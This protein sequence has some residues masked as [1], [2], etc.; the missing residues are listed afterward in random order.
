MTEQDER[1][2]RC[3]IWIDARPE[4]VFEFFVEPEKMVR[5]KGV[6][7]ELD[8]RPGGT[9]YVDVT[10]ADVARGEYV[11]LDPPRRVVFTW[12]WEAAGHPVPVG[13]STVEVTLTP[14]H[15][16]TLVQLTHRDLPADTGAPHLEGWGHY[17]ARLAVAAAGRDPG[18]DPWVAAARQAAG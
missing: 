15:N 17:L 4:T 14:Q 13:S 5:W 1:A 16:G 18:P 3:E 2:V 6:A 11:V 8:P 7:A 12:G 9:Y 10:G